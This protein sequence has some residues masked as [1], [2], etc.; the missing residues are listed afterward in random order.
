MGGSGAQESSLKARPHDQEKKIW[1]GSPAPFLREK[2]EMEEGV[3]CTF[4][5]CA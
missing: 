5:K 3:L 4:E 1:G 2:G